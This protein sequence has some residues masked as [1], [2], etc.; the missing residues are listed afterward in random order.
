MK[1]KE[2]LIHRVKRAKGQ[3][4]AVEKMI[5]ENRACLDTI[6]QISA[7]R[8]AL[9]KVGIELLKNEA[10]VCATK[11]KGKNFEEIIEKLFKLK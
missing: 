4:S 5:E 7:A 11:P 2:K 9:A 1:N 3:I 8:S 10:Y 6:Q